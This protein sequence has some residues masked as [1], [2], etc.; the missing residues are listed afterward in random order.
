MQYSDRRGVAEM[1]DLILFITPMDLD[2]FRET[3]L[4]CGFQSTE[5]FMNM[6]TKLEM[7]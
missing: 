6:N 2:I 5:V 4:M 1:N 7:L 3:L